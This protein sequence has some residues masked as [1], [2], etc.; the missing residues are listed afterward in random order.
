MSKFL[1]LIFAVCGL[2]LAGGMATSHAQTATPD[3]GPLP[4]R[5]A[6]RQAAR[7]APG[8]N[9][10]LRFEPNNAAKTRTFFTAP[11]QVIVFGGPVCAEGST[12]WQVRSLDGQW[13]GWIAEA[14]EG[15]Y[16]LNPPSTP[17]PS[18]TPRPTLTSTP[19][20]N[21][22]GTA[23]ARAQSSS[24]ALAVTRAFATQAALNAQAN[25]ATARAQQTAQAAANRALATQGILNAQAT[26][27]VLA[28]FNAQSTRRAQAQATQA[29]LAGQTQRAAVLATGTAQRAF[30]QQRTSTARANQAQVAQTQRA[31]ALATGTAS[32]L[33]TRQAQTATRNAQNTAAVLARTQS[34]QSTATAAVW[35]QYLPSTFAGIDSGNLNGQ[36]VSVRGYVV[37]WD[38]AKRIVTL[39][40]SPGRYVKVFLAERWNAPPVVRLV[41]AAPGT[42]TYTPPPGYTFYGIADGR[43]DG[44]PSL[45]Q[46]F[47]SK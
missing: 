37:S 14:V 33:N 2:M 13:E 20:P 38:S 5:L 29:I 34:A 1:H 11:T 36:R 16:Q 26:A 23:Q 40:T 46:A 3:C 22:T 25:Q 15:S 24:T 30:D 35:A 47:W 28:T 9:V 31:V 12:W 7:I 10:R 45:L 44:K 32:V 8:A 17:V 21:R 39:E 4:S 42:P 41:T 27:Q 18:A 6:L 43:Q 19:T